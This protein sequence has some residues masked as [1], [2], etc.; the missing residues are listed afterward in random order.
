MAIEGPYTL[1]L[2][3]RS[4]WELTDLRRRLGIVSPDLQVDFSR[5]MSGLDAVVSGFF[6][7]VGTWDSHRVS[8]A[9]IA[10]ARRALERVGAAHLGIR[11]MTAMSSGEARRILIAR[12]LIHGPDALLLDEPTT[13]LD[14]R[15]H[16]E[17]RSTMRRLA[18]G[19]TAILLV[20]HMLEDVIPEIS[21]VVLLRRGVIFKDGPAEEVLTSAS[22]SELFETRVRLEHADGI[23]RLR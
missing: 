21:R 7:S 19:G 11:L 6:G 1:R 12:A 2:L 15:A 5:E 3:G 16:L 18:R 9:Q 10:K 20:T 23:W 22:L 13:S 17:F 14:F 8:P 4:R